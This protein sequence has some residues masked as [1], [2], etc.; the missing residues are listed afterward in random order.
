MTAV[1]SAMS[2]E[3][4]AAM[5]A[6][7]GFLASVRNAILNLRIPKQDC[8]EVVQQ[9]FTVALASKNLPED[10]TALREYVV[11]IA[12]NQAKMFRRKR[13]DGV[14]PFN[15]K[16]HGAALPAGARDAAET[17]AFLERVASQIPEN[18]WSTFVWLLRMAKDESLQDIAREEGI[19]Y[20][21]AHSRVDRLR[22]DIARWSLHVTVITTILICVIGFWPLY[23]PAFEF[24]DGR[25]G[26]PGVFIEPPP[27]RPARRPTAA[28]KFHADELRRHA[29]DECAEQRWDDCRD[30]LDEAA[31]VDPSGDADPL[32]AR[33]R[34]ELSTVPDGGAP[35]R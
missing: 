35:G 6:D 26:A 34:Q 13:R 17:R 12:R 20:A 3:R 30:D 7:A 19:T 29:E 32:A 33:L 15:E 27:P 28:E 2:R 18:R 4:I 1:A 9:A 16:A 5:Y 10:E 23:E 21:A 11:G 8:M 14:E 24:D 22:Q 25:V 31:A